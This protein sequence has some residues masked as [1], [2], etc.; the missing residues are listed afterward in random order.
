MAIG[1]MGC[2]GRRGWVCRWAGV[3]GGGGGGCVDVLGGRGGGRNS[4]MFTAKMN[5]S[6]VG[7]SAIGKTFL[8]IGFNHPSEVRVKAYRRH[9]G[10]KAIG[11]SEANIFIEHVPVSRGPI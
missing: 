6:A 10:S 5:Q 11:P 9:L 3:P 7:Q 8:R 1:D 4:E 2:Q